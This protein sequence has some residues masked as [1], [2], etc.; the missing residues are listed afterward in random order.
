MAKLEDISIKDTSADLTEAYL[1]PEGQMCIQRPDGSGEEVILGGFPYIATSE[2]EGE[3]C[4]TFVGFQAM[5]RECLA[6]QGQAEVVLSPRITVRVAAKTDADGVV[7]AKVLVQQ[8]KGIGED[9]RKGVHLQS[10]LLN[11]EATRVL[12]NC[13]VPS[14]WVTA[15]GGVT[16]ELDP[17]VD[18]ALIA[19]IERA[20]SGTQ[21]DIIRALCTEGRVTFRSMDGTKTYKLE[22]G[23]KGLMLSDLAGFT[24]DGGS[25]SRSLTG[26]E[27]Q[28]LQKH[29]DHPTIEV[30]RTPPQAPKSG[31]NTAGIDTS[32][33]L[34]ASAVILL[35]VKRALS[36]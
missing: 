3:D 35:A 21:Q 6:A 33:I 27:I 29:R 1:N 11:L 23:D 18:T 14:N 20:M 7:Q 34:V 26:L 24:G 25:K 22:A 4:G 17:S 8:V 15:I 12:D 31:C 36:R 19:D 16:I 30:D 5:D 9:A 28:A 2:F 10:G 13:E 32:G